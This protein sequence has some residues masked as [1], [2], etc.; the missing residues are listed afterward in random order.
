[1]TH[2]VGDRVRLEDG[3]TGIVVSTADDGTLR[4][5][6]ESGIIISSALE[7]DDDG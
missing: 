2:H 1:M 7:D 5:W 4:L 6:T 3:E